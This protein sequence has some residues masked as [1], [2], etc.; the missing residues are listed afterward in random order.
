MAPFLEPHL[1]LR[2]VVALALACGLLPARAAAPAPTVA[3]AAAPAAE[4]PVR[5]R[6][7]ALYGKLPLRFEA[8]A[9]QIDDRT[10]RFLGRGAG[11][12]L[13]LTAREAILCP[14][15]RGCGH[16]AAVR[17]GVAGGTG[18]PRVTGIDPLP[19]KSNYF[20]GN[21]PRRW[22]LGV[23]SYAAVR[24]EGV[25]P[26]V[27]LVFHG[28]ARR[29]EYD[30]LI[31]PGADPRRLRLSFAGAG[32]LRLGA[33]GELILHTPGGDL[34]Q[35]APVAYQQDGERRE[36]V[37]ARFVL[38]SSPAS[39]AAGVE[40]SAQVGFALGRFDRS[41][42]LVIDP[43]L[44]YSTY[45]GGTDSD[46]GLAIAVDGAGNAYV[47]GSTGSMTFPG[48]GPGSIQPAYGGGKSNAFVT[49][50]NAAGTAIVYSTYLGG[51]GG[52]AGFAIAVDA[53]GN[54][55]LGGSTTSPN[56]PGV[57][58]ASIQP[59]LNGG[60]DAFVTKIDPTGSAIVYSTYLGGS[61][62]DEI[63]ALAVDALGDVYVAGQTGSHDF[64]GASSSSIQP[65]HSVGAQDAFVAKINAVGTAI[66]WSTYLGGGSD[67][68]DGRG[69]AVDGAGAAYVTGRTGSLS[70]PG[71]NA[72]SIQPAYGGGAYDAFVTKIN[73]AGTAIVYST[74]LGGKS[75]DEG[76]GIAV[77]AGGS[78]YVTGSS[79]SS[80]FPGFGSDSIVPPDASG[81]RSVFV[82][83]IDAAGNAIAYST[84]LGFG[85][86]AG[87][88]L[89][90]ADEA[91]VTGEGNGGAARTPGHAGIF[92]TKINAAGTAIVDALTLGGLGASFPSGIA[93]DG[94]GNAY[95]TGFTA[96][97]D[98]SGTASS[99]IQPVHAG[100]GFDAY[101]TKVGLQSAGAAVPTLSPWGIVLMALLLGA[102]RLLFV[103]PR[104]S[105]A[106]GR[107]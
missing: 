70:F 72:A 42:P 65:M 18:Q 51:T 88:G 76:F 13:L 14:D 19:G 26:G 93:V 29:L 100:G 34:V 74:F 107:R 43:V 62:G 85:H 78:A 9:G 53:L 27:D 39:P 35:P 24:Y 1:L 41:R 89:D 22:H 102:A 33:R 84:S 68:D 83:K 7:S 60:A 36:P 80:N 95:V 94:P 48:V 75:D 57:S 71:V 47:T 46:A 91:V 12:T 44:V 16:G 54:A 58:P 92:V 10:V 28:E 40:P 106:G 90:A 45:L 82:T 96:A 86:G 81:S 6:V 25:Y 31:S 38:L 99:S 98:F 17:L 23:A 30:F 79:S 103:R 87:I 105:G 32:P 21:D 20:I 104:R 101:V 5:A 15:R 49:K 61:G 55:Y 97:H 37:A 64:P 67:V 3:L 73:A 11:Y 4:S 8:N 77:D 52:D 66:A 59:A 50:I 2:A 69:I 56:F 63:H